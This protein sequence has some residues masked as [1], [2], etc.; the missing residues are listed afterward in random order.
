MKEIEDGV[1]IKDN[2][3]YFKG[4]KVIEVSDIVLFG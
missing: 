2:V 3:F 4:E 1:C